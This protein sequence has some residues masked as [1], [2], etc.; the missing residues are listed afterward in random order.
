MAEEDKIEIPLIMAIS[1]AI[2]WRGG[3]RDPSGESL[4]SLDVINETWKALSGRENPPHPEIWV[5]YFL[6]MVELYSQKVCELSKGA[7]RRFGGRF[8][9]FEY[10]REGITGISFK[11]E[12]SV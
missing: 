9:L 12:N 3:N 8:V 6:R 11:K 1:I 5:N 7:G 2:H 4:K 10:K